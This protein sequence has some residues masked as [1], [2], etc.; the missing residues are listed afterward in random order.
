MAKSKKPRKSYNPNKILTNSPVMIRYT[1]EEGDIMKFRIYFHLGR[2]I[3]DEAST[4]DYL[5]LKFRINVGKELSKLFEGNEVKTIMDDGI[6]L[7]EQ[8]KD[9]RLETGSWKI[10]LTLQD[11]LRYVLSIID[12]IQD[13]TTRKEQL[14]IFIAVEK[15]LDHSLIDRLP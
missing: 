13:K 9:R 6:N 14:P 1:K 12:D 5:A 10:D 11:K 2:I 4:G 15:Q 3:T 8:V 7:I